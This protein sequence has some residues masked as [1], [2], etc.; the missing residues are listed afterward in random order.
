MVLNPEEIKTILSGTHFNKAMPLAA[1]KQPWPRIIPYD[2]YGLS[3]FFFV[4]LRFN[5]SLC[6]T[7]VSQFMVADFSLA[8]TLETFTSTYEQSSNWTQTGNV[9]TT[10]QCVVNFLFLYFEVTVQLP[11]YL[12]RKHVKSRCKR[13]RGVDN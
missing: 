1:T 6:F 10:G 3:I 9:L 5:C 11:N 13:R 2:L 4:F 12:T 7:S 8:I